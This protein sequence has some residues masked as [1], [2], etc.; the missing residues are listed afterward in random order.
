MRRET[1]AYHIRHFFIFSMKTLHELY[2]E[3]TASHE[4]KKAFAEAGTKAER[5]LSP[6][7]LENG[8]S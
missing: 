8:T 6:E 1:E 7:E 3:I 5:E 2:S 4:L